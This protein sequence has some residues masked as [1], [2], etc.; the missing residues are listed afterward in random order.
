MG[1]ET[2]CKTYSSVVY[3]P[4]IL[5]FIMSHYKEKKTDALKSERY[6]DE[7]KKTLDINTDRNITV[8]GTYT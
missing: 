6:V 3:I 8:Q 7:G 4:Y 2:L 1:F 5:V